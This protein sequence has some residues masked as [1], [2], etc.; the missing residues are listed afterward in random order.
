MSGRRE[1]L[2]NEYAK[3]RER[4]VGNAGNA[5][6]GGGHK[7]DPKNQ[8]LIQRLLKFVININVSFC[9]SLIGK[10][11][12]WL[13][14][15]LLGGGG[16][17]VLKHKGLLPEFAGSK[18]PP[19][20]VL[21]GDLSESDVASL[22]SYLCPPE[23]EMVQIYQFIVNSPY[24]QENSQYAQIINGIPFVYDEKDDDV[25]A[26]AS[27]EEVKTKD[28]LEL[29]RKMTLLGGLVR[30]SRLLGLAAS[31]ENGH[32]GILKQTV[33][34]MPDELLFH[35][36]VT[37]T[38]NFAIQEGLYAALSDEN[39]RRQ[40]LSFSSGML[41]GVLAHEAGHH[42]LG[43]LDFNRKMADDIQRDKEM[44]ADSFAS[45][46]TKANATSSEYMLMGQM[47]FWY[48]LSTQYG[49]EKGDLSSGDHPLARW[50]LE[51]LIRQNDN[52]AASLGLKLD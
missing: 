27:R 38:G 28:G 13:L 51:T 6:N 30:Y 42:A 25:N 14:L 20:V 8:S 44:Q 17:G 11:A 21:D 46:I 48:A 31:L 40:A 23:S 33:E 36:S 45:A 2:K 43:H 34:R 12:L 41:M 47:L 15:V 35:S 10:G 39:A 52:L 1:M 7:S 37:A 18:E 32:P 9:S 4:Y 49:E 19:P 22:V 24:V 26:Y 5:G 29:V 16:I 50:R 3:R